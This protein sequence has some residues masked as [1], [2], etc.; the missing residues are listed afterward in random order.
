MEKLFT[1]SGG[2]QIAGHLARPRIAPGTFV[3]GLVIS[4]GFPHMQE[5]GR[6]SAM[7]FPELAERIATEM[8]WMVLVYTFR[9][10]GDSEG[11]FSLLGWRG[12]RSGSPL[13]PESRS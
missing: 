9:G 13:R 2:I 8:G 11:D 6:L 12:C 5:G 7:S 3:P 4:H 1:S 10:C